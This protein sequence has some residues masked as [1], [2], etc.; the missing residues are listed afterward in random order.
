ML[1]FCLFRL[2]SVQ[3]VKKGRTFKLKIVAMLKI[4]KNNKLIEVKKHI[5]NLL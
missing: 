2:K 5:G 4:D 3:E 1:L